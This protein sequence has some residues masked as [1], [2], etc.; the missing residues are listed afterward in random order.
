VQI[1]NPAALMLERQQRLSP[2]SLLVELLLL[3]RL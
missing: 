2:V 1:I 3:D